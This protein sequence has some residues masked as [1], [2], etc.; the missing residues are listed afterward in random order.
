LIQYKLQIKRG[1]V[2]KRLSILDSIVAAENQAAEMKREAAAQARDMI[3]DAEQAAQEETAALILQARE[4][5]KAALDQAEEAAQ[6]EAKEFVAQR[7]D[8]YEQMA[9]SARAKLPQAVDYIVG[10]VVS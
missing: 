1:K 10:R 5:A 9:Q 2:V 7:A 3:R 4:E 6:Q 8:A